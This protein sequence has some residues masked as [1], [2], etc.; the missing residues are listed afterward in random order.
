MPTDLSYSTSSPLTTRGGVA[1]QG[2]PGRQYSLLP[3]Q[4]SFSTSD[5][6][7][8]GSA[9]SG[10][11]ALA[12]HAVGLTRLL[13]RLNGTCGC[14][15]TFH[16][17]AA[18]ASWAD[19][20]NREFYLDAGFLDRMLAH[21]R[22]TGWDVVTL[23]E[24]LHRAATGER[25][26]FVN[27]S[28]DDTYRDTYEIVVPAFRRAGVP[29]TLFVTT[30][31]PDNTLSLWG[32][33][34]ETIL[35]ES[36]TIAVPCGTGTATLHLTDATQRR[37]VFTALHTAW[38]QAG[39]EQMYRI[40]CA[41]NG[42]DTTALHRR[43]AMDWDMLATLRHDP[44]VEIGAHTVG[45]RRISTLE[46]AEAMAEIGGSRTRLEEKLGIAVRHF[47]FPYGRA[48]DCGPRDFALVREAGY[49]SAATTRKGLVRGGA[50]FDPYALP[51]NALNG[52]HQRTA[53]T[54]FHLSGL[55]GLATRLLR[56][57]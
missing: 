9:L 4:R 6:P 1:L 15:L 38:E 44:C 51:R 18:S 25:G 41:L 20:P 30:G 50:G 35:A 47:A 11:G 54:A 52:A 27:I 45:H 2:Y 13:E 46:P 7:W 34:L 33:G 36:A 24:A 48:A 53:Q 12:A 42:Y 10:A 19:L 3:D 28:V 22:A 57:G 29:V 21:L 39:P 55:S 31:I 5:R 16:R 17:A 37:Q 26:R 14:M 49:A 8:R 23:D 40:F 32:A 56:K 43:H